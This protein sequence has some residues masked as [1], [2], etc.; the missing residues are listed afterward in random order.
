MGKD[1][2]QDIWVSKKDAS[3]A[4][5]MAEHLGSPYNI[6]RSEPGAYNFFGW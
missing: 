5:G 3:G 6:H 4:W 1:D 2:T